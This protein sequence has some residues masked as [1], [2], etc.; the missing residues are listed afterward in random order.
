MMNMSYAM[1]DLTR[2][3]LPWSF[4]ITVVPQWWIWAVPWSIWHV[5]YCLDYFRSWLCHNDEYELCNDRSYTFTIA[6]IISDHCCATVMNMSCAMIDL[7]RLLLPWL[8]PIMVVQND[9]YELCHDRSDTFTIALIISDHGCATMMNMSC[10]MIDLTCLLLPWLFPIMVVPQWWIWAVPWSIWHVYCCLNPFRSWLCH[11]D[12]YELCLDR[13]DTFTIALIISDH[14]CAKMMNMSYAMIDLTR[15][16]LPWSFPI[17]V[18]PQWWI[19]AVPWSIWHVYYCLDYFRSWLCHN[20]EYELCN[21]RS[22]TFTIALIISDHCCATVMNMSCAMIDLTRLLLPWLFPIMVVQNDEYE[23]CHDRSD[24][25]TIALIISDHGCATM[26]N[27]SCAMIDLT[28]LLLPWLFPIMVVP[29]WWIWAVPWS[30]WHVYC[31]L[32]PFRSWLCHSDEYELCLDRSDT[33]TIALIISDHGCATMMNMSYAMIDLTR[34]LLPWLFPIMT[35]SQ[36]WIWAVPW[37]IWH[38]YCCLNPFRSW[39]CHSDEY[40]LCLDRS[41]TFTIALIISDHGCATMMNM[42]YAMIDLTCLL[43]PWS[44][45]ITV[46][47]QWWVWAVPWLIWHVFCCLDHFRSRLCNNDEYEL[48][49][50]QS[51]TLVIALIISDHG[52]ATM[53]ST[54]YAMINPTRYCNLDQLGSWLCHSDEYKLCHNRSDTFYYHL[55]HTR[56]WLCHND[57]YELCHYWCYT[58]T[59]PLIISYHGCATVM[60]ISCAMINLIRLLLPWSYPITVVPQWWI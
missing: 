49:H 59:I 41:D 58:F 53:M 43:L 45:P 11:S 30:I 39:L 52:C 55:D 19:W 56:S 33:F 36:W 27:M 40:E 44:F 24:T 46:V 6:L 37:S 16:L 12:E 18:V 17:T 7:T 15:L 25:F 29:Q 57:E 48:C 54:S 35:V 26:M 1:I 20:D 38:V 13:S 3:L 51:D 47:P 9:E 60:N 2:L 42:S 31:C 8:F 4:P 23:L 5:Y 10:A 50:D 21:D 14:G 22:Y 28:C 32:N 34:L